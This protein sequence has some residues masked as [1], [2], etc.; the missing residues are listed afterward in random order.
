MKAFNNII[1]PYV[2][3]LSLLGWGLSFWCKEIN[4]LI[5]WKLLVVIPLILFPFKVLATLGGISTV[6]SVG[7]VGPYT[8]IALDSTGNPHIGYY[9]Y[10]QIS[11]TPTI[12]A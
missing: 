6:D 2:R 12:M 10:F 1:L 3:L 7:N 11:S 9:D 4:K 8:S 5:L